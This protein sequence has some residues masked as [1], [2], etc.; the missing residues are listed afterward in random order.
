MRYLTHLRI[1]LGAPQPWS[2]IWLKPLIEAKKVRI[3]GILAKRSDGSQ[4]KLSITSC[5]TLHYI[6]IFIFTLP[7]LL[8]F[9]NDINDNQ[10]HGS[11]S[12]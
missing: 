6:N 9:T 10:Q 5:I 7:N 3:F 1:F 8:F 2:A 12:L 11:H 4:R